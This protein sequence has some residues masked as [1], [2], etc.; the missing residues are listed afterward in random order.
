MS[1]LGTLGSIAS[2]AGLVA[3]F[4]IAVYQRRQALEARKEAA[5]ERARATSLQDHLTRQQWQHLRSLGKQIDT[6]EGEGRTTETAV[7]AAMHA[8]LKE[9][10]RSLLGVVATSTPGFSASTV[11]DWI[12]VGRLLRPW[13][14]AEAIS[15][16]EVSATQEESADERQLLK[17]LLDSTRAVPRVAEIKTPP[18]P[19]PYV[20]AF[21]LVGHVV[22][23]SLRGLLRNA[24]DEVVVAVLLH[25]LALD[26]LEMGSLEK[27]G[28]PKFR[29]WGSDSAAPLE[30]R[31]KYYRKQD[32]WVIHGVA[33]RVRVKLLQFAGLF[34]NSSS[35]DPPH[36]LIPKDKAAEVLGRKFPKIK[37]NSI[38]L[39]D[40]RFNS[41]S[42]I[43]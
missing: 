28:G 42:A 39:L 2:L 8:G 13:Q 26:C 17:D 9:Q 4:I 14:I 5:A 16:L 33:E 29:C 23:D 12:E 37:R 10:Y 25:Y 35:S 34:E 7:D 24:S 6:L 41:E 38:E 31:F 43:S 22:R 27:I 36:F 18:E 21:V 11:R 32:Y 19:T 1:D 20:A 3:G 15:Y 40:H 30:E